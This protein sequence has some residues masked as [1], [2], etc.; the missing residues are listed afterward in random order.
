MSHLVKDTHKIK[1]VLTGAEFLDNK[2]C[3]HICLGD[4]IDTYFEN[5]K[6]DLKIETI[7]N[8]WND[9]KKLFSDHEYLQSLYCLGIK[10]ISKCMNSYHNTKKL[11]DIGNNNWSMAI[12]IFSCYF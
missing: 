6:S 8:P 1:L 10:K 4:W 9:R 11:K 5:K 2:N 12:I 3:L 7:E